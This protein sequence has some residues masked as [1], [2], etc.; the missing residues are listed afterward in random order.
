MRILTTDIYEG[1][2]LLSQGMA[3]SNIWEDASKKKR[4]VVFEF[5]GDN[6]GVLR[7]N[8]LRGQASANI[9]K[10]K[11]SITEIKDVMFNL[12]RTQELRGEKRDVIKRKEVY[13]HT[14]SG[15]KS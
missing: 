8:Y 11:N 4:S 1:A 2:Y 3:L 12:L 9:F 5:E 15:Y 7:K 14:V 6:I 13:R 10:F